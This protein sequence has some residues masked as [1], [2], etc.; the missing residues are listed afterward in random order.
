MSVKEKYDKIKS[1]LN[2][3]VSLVAVVKGQPYEKLQELFDS[4]QRIFAENKVQDLLDKI[5]HLNNPE[6]KWH[7]IGHLQRNK[8]KYIIDKVELIHSLDS[9]K[10]AE[11]ISNRAL[12][13][14]KVMECLIQ[15]NTGSEDNK[16]GINFDTCE[17]FLSDLQA[18]EGI[19]IIG[20][21]A[22]TPYSENPEDARPYFK[23]MK[24]NNEE[25]RIIKLVPREEDSNIRLDSFLSKEIDEISGS[26][27]QK[28]I[29]NGSVSIDGTVCYSKKEKMSSSL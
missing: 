21:M 28:L 11:E 3:G 1:S 7:F 26:F 6:I 14:G 2:E 15:I 18:F 24:S 8:V 12:K 5:D 22:V 13:A 4:G 23:K 16:Y 25:D 9:I 17:N 20:L 19:R 27:I 29:D 10:L